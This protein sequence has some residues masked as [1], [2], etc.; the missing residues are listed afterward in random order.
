MH[1]QPEYK[2]TEV[3]RLCGI[4]NRSL[5]LAMQMIDESLGF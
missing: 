2:K 1:V 5:G 3:K 4:A